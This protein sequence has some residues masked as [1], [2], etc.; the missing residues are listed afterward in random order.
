M[1][2]LMPTMSKKSLSSTDA[3]MKRNAPSYRREG[4][5]W[6]RAEL[7][8]SMNEKGVSIS[9]DSLCL[10]KDGSN[11]TFKR[12]RRVVVES[13]DDRKFAYRLL[14]RVLIRAIA[15]NGQKHDR[16]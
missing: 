10:A 1:H 16:H 6:I 8:E 11:C 7:K 2:A 13:N 14:I 9:N 5:L 3:H 12:E 15:Y 4:K